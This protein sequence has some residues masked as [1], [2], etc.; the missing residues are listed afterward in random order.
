LTTVCITIIIC[1]PFCNYCN[2][3]FFVIIKIQNPPSYINT[4]YELLLDCHNTKSSIIYQYNP[5]YFI[6]LASFLFYLWLLKYLQIPTIHNSIILSSFFCT[7]DWIKT[8]QFKG[9]ATTSLISNSTTSVIGGFIS[10]FCLADNSTK[11]YDGFAVAHFHDFCW[12][13]HLYKDIKISFID[14]IYHHQLQQVH[15]HH[16]Y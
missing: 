11:S 6:N 9:F 14:T 5:K 15:Q 7:C 16:D 13:N 1:L 12:L 10:L 2:K 8:Q 4:Q 3:N